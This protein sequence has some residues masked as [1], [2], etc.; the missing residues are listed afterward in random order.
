M[1]LKIVD[2]GISQSIIDQDQEDYKPKQKE[3]FIPLLYTRDRFFGGAYS[4]KTDVFCFGC[5]VG[6]LWREHRLAHPEDCLC[7]DG[8]GK[9]NETWEQFLYG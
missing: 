7:Q 2:F 6:E 3:A 4:E 8:L 1:E 5:L 9:D